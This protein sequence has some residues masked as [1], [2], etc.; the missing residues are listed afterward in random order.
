MT[1][2]S[3]CSRGSIVQ[4]KQEKWYG[5]VRHYA[6]LGEVGRC[7]VKPIADSNGEPLE[8]P[9]GFFIKESLLS[10]SGTDIPWLNL[11]THFNLFCWKHPASRQVTFEDNRTATV[12]DDG[13]VMH[14]GEFRQIWLA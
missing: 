13:Y 8:I 12:T 9:F 7:C 10:A 2:K 3:V 4:H 5:I 6:S 1:S 14:V 11:K